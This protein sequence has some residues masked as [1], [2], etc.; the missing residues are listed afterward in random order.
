MTTFLPSLP[1]FLAYTAASILLFATPGPDM[2]LFL[3]R[4][5]SSGRRAGI[6]SA[7]GSNMGCVVHTLLAAFG[8]S[9]LIAASHTGF[10]ILK[11]VGAGYLLWLAV[12]AI[13]HG[14]SL[15]V[16]AQGNAKADTLQSF[17][18]GVLVNMTNPKVVIFF[19][20]FL[21]QFITAGDP[22]V[23]GKLLFFGLYF[24]LLNIPLSIITVLV[25]EKLVNWL[26]ARP[27]VLRGIDFTFAGVFAL[28]ALKIA[29]TEGRH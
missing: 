24:V 8:V 2:S 25:A 29:F 23:R 22:D 3:S 13:R 14:S 28:F 9:A 16:A 21:P 6:A 15:N 18:M 10:L 19:I 4:T 26:K 5:I 12:D 1:V 7:M 27:R 20:T 11:I 17:G